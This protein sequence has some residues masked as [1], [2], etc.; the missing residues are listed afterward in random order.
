L[1]TTSDLLVTATIVAV[2]TIAAAIDVRTRRI[3]NALTGTTAGAA[4]ALGLAGVTGLSLAAVL[5]GMAIGFVLLLPGHVL[6]ATGAG[7]VKLLASLG[8]LL[9]PAG[10]LE[11]F[12]YTAIAGGVLALGLAASRGRLTATVHGAMRLVTAPAA[13]R[14]AARAAGSVNRF[15]YGPAIAVGAILAAW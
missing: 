9:G 7:D 13:G 10:V 4:I 2:A 14:V 1:S 12:V 8:G 6:G 3:P 15:P 11:A 5:G